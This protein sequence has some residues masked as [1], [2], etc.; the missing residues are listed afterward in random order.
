MTNP[1]IKALQELQD[2]I[3]N[4]PYVNQGHG[5]AHVA[6][7]PMPP[8]MAELAIRL[9]ESLTPSENFDWHMH[10]NDL[11]GKHAGMFIGDTTTS[12]TLEPVTLLKIIQDAAD[13]HI[14][15]LAKRISDGNQE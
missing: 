8:Q 14:N 10:T 2:H 7:K 6:V 9:I 5:R 15:E 13:T 4:S 1:T 3:G 11:L 12:I